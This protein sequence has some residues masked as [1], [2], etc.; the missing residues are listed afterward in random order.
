MLPHTA[1][2]EA[3]SRELERALLDHE[4][5]IRTAGLLRNRLDGAGMGAGRGLTVSEPALPV[6]ADERV[7]AQPTVQD[8]LV[9]AR[10]ALAA[11]RTHAEG[12]RALDTESYPVA[13][14][15][16]QLDR[17]IEALEPGRG[18][19][20]REWFEE[21]PAPEARVTRLMALLE[22]ARLQRILLGQR[23]GFGPVLLKR[24]A[25]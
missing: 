18:V 6:E 8:A 3:P 19:S 15:L 13:T 24:L 10:R 14:I 4:T 5:L 2:V 7:P 17:R 16:A 9:A 22:L 21:L 25:G 20:T 12:S 1:G 11:A 23:E